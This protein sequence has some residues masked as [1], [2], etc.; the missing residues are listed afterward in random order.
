MSY[1]KKY[2]CLFVIVCV[3]LLFPISAFSQNHIINATLQSKGDRE[4]MMGVS[5]WRESLII[6]GKRVYIQ[7]VLNE[8]ARN[9][10][11]RRRYRNRLFLLPK[12]VVYDDV[13]K[14]IYYYGDNTEIEVGRYKKFLGLMPYL[15]LSEGVRIVSS[16][17][18]AKLLISSGNDDKKFMQSIIHSE[19]SME[20]T[21]G[22]KCGQCHI[23]EYIFS[24]KKWVEEDVLHAFNRMQMEEME[25]FTDEEQK[26]I[27][28]FK[29]FQLGDL[30]KSKLSEFAALK[31]IGENDVIDMTEKVY[32][33]NC[34]PC[35][36]PSKM[37]KI[38]I[39]YSKVRCRSI[40]DR[41]KEKEPTLF[42]DTDLDEIAG[43]LW[44]I[45]SKSY[46]N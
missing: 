25:A 18:D 21:L 42:L 27:D 38:S 1:L 5:V 20:V 14:C 15:S 31:K 45:K 17:T 30:N 11:D 22:E 34:V 7:I 40:V 19:E 6:K 2:P 13:S 41:M 23:L 28:L 10:A 24:H 29:K 8:G 3:N 33:N 35:H 36:N 16:V 9:I 44:K 37:D 4:E 26:V 12:E 32:T 43:Y 39:Q 46:G